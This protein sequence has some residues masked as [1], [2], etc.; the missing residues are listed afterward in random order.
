MYSDI[1]DQILPLVS[2]PSRYVAAE[3]N[4]IRKPHSEDKVKFVLSFPEVYEIGMSHLGLKILYHIINKRDDAIAERAYAPWM[5]ME[6]EMRLREIPMLSHDSRTPLKDFD[7]LG[8]SLQY[9]LTYTNVLNMIDM[10]GISVWSSQREEDDPIILAGGP[11]VTNPEPLSEFIDAFVIGD[12]ED[13]IHKI[14]DVF[15]EYKGDRERVLG[16]LAKIGGVYVPALYEVYYLDNGKVKEIRPKIQGIPQVVRRTWVETLKEEYYPEKPIVPVQEITQDRLTI[17]VLRGCTQG[18][19]FCQAGYYYRPVRER[20]PENILKMAQKGISESGWDEMSLVSLSTADHSCVEKI[21]EMLSEEFS[22]KNVAISLPSLRADRFSVNLAE[23][24]GE[25]SRTGFTFAPETGS[26]RLRNVLNKSIKNEELYR[27][28]EVAYRSGWDLVKLYFM[29]GLP[30]ETDDD[31]QS[32]VDMARRVNEIGKRAGGNK[33]VNVSVGCHVPKSHTPFQWDG[34]EDMESL[35]GKIELLKSSVRNRWS[36]LK[37]HDVEPS[38]VEAVFSKGDRKVGRAIYE[39]WKMGARFDGWSENFDFGLWMRAFEAAGVDP[40]FHTGPKD[41]KD[42]LPWDV[43]DIAVTKKFLIRERMKMFEGVLTSDCRWG[44][45]HACGIPGMPDDNKLI[46][47]EPQVSFVEVDMDALEPVIDIEERRNRKPFPTKRHRVRHAVGEEFRFVSNRDMMQAF[48]RAIRMTGLPIAYSQGFTPRPKVSFGPPLPVGMT[49]IS[50]F[51]DLELDERFQGDLVEIMND[52]LPLGLMILTAEPLNG[53]V[54]SLSSIIKTALYR[55]DFPSEDSR[56]QTVDSRQGRAKDSRQGIE[57]VQFALDRFDE[58]DQFLITKKGKN[59]DKKVDLKNAVL[60][61]ELDRGIDSIG[62]DMLLCV[63]DLDR[64]NVNPFLVMKEVLDFDEERVAS[65][66]VE[67]R[68]M[69]DGSGGLIEGVSV[70]EE[71]L[72]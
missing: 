63:G 35:K 31:V 22:D 43:I 12:G 50:E 34:F 58:S 14:I 8:F 68:G 33:R 41:I 6:R 69:F 5:D 10:A 4:L 70:R 40:Y 30:T 15:K 65:T 26:Q 16:N 11:C 47:D 29:I 64:G 37:W 32:I 66:K 59:Q 28:V 57:Q 48:H 60:M 55:V 62:L 21:T 52:K 42:V 19:R 39:A 17:E 44:Q 67:R 18:C 46:F 71:V 72:V 27:A 36:K 49:S 23:N 7:F 1:I 20:S 2:K 9:E 45:C 3:R 25:T 38:F 24:V 13:V 53:K 56:Q 61:I 54:E 51:M